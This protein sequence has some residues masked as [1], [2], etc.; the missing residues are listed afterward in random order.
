MQNKSKITHKTELFWGPVQGKS[1]PSFI[2][3]IP[4]QIRLKYE[5][6]N[7]HLTHYQH[8]VVCMIVTKGKGFKKGC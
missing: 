5:M 4:P 1:F 8:I 6:L 7:K 3:K 2:L